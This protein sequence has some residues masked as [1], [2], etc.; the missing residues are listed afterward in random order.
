M[1]RLAYD[2]KKDGI[3]IA[4]DVRTYAEALKIKSENAGSSITSVYIPIEEKGSIISPKRQEM[5]AKY[6]YVKVPKGVI[7]YL[8]KTERVHRLSS[9]AV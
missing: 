7:N 4:K 2:V 9:T 3:V 5:L 6:G 8:R 1:T